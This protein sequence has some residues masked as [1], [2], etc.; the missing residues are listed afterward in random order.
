MRRPYLSL[1]WS[2]RSDRDEVLKLIEQ[3]CGGKCRVSGAYTTL[4][5]F[6]APAVQ[7]LNR[8]EKY[9][10]IKRH[11]ARVV[12]ELLG[13][14]HKV[15]LAQAYLK[16][17]RRVRS[18]PLPNFPSRK[19]AAGYFDGDGC[20]STRIGKSRTSATVVA[21]IVASEYDRE[22]LDLLHKAFGGTIANLS[23]RP[24][25]A[26][27]TLQ[28]PPS[29]AKEILGH[30]GKYMIVKK[31]Q[32]DFILGCAQMGHYRDGGSISAALKQLKAQP[33]RL[34]EPNAAL[35]LAG[36]RDVPD[37]EILDRKRCA[38]SHAR[39]LRKR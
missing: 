1:E 11:Y 21:E 14:P 39:S 12:L 3:Q 31:A 35:L 20:F 18:D 30:F 17:Q 8:M 29:K 19:W 32:A 25:L 13:K 33:H 6:G 4:K 10:V 36:V 9:L 5:V 28:M 15:E 16:A 37:E 2:Q 7:L 24:H 27:W 26:K 23:D 38:M 34:S 22:G